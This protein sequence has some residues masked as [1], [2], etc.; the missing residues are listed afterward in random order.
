MGIFH[1][2]AGIKE[3]FLF[4]FYPRIS[5]W[6]G[7]VFKF[8]NSGTLKEKTTMVGAPSIVALVCRSRSVYRT[9]SW[10]IT[11]AANDF[12]VVLPTFPAGL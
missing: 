4:I 2:P 10:L 6:Q 7:R 5:F 9:H 11:A 12:V 1:I 8:P 3:Q